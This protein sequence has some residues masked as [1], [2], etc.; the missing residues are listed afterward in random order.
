MTTP[1]NPSELAK[2]HTH[3]PSAESALIGDP[4]RFG[5]VGEDGTVFVKTPN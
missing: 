5:F 1:H 4:S 2:N 3:A